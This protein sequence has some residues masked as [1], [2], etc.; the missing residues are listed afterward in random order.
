[1]FVEWKQLILSTNSGE[2]PT[3]AWQDCASAGCE[4]GV[5][6]PWDPWP[7]KELGQRQA[8]CCSEVGGLEVW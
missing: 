7:Q 3:A 1:M 6:L 2:E 4:Q 8:D 5:V